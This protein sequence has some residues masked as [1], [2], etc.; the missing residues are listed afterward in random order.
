MKM[1]HEEDDDH[2]YGDDSCEHNIGRRGSSALK[3]TTSYWKSPIGSACDTKEL[4]YITA[5]HQT[6]DGD[7]DN[8]LDGSIDGK[9]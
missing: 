6:S 4:E 2:H 3:K 7:D 5:L 9:L 8:W 1:N